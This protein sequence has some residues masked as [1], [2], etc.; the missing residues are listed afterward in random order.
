MSLRE[1]NGP[2]CLLWL[3]LLL[4]GAYY[5]NFAYQIL[6]NANAAG[7]F[8]GNFV[9]ML[10]LIVLPA[11]MV[12]FFTGYLRPTRG[13]AKMTM[14]GPSV[15]LGLIF[16]IITFNLSL[17]PAVEFIISNALVFS[18]WGIGSAILIAG[19]FSIAQ[20]YEQSTSSGI[21]DVSKLHYGPPKEEPEIQ[22]E[23]EMTKEQS[24]SSEKTPEGE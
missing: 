2:Y 20:S 5:T 14:L 13:K 1:D 11:I 21:M 6:T 3:G 19:G 7:A 15:F 22:P 24:N 16:V 10:V 17:M 4:L 8:Y 23:T 18:A 12:F 9:L